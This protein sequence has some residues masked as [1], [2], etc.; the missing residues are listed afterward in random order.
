MA[1]ATLRAL[2]AGAAVLAVAVAAGC[3]GSSAPGTTESTGTD[4]TE[5]TAAIEAKVTAFVVG[6]LVCVS[7][8]E[9]GDL[10]VTWT[11]QEATAVRLE[12]DGADADDAGPSGSSVLSMPCDG[13]LHKVSVTALN[14]SG[15]GQTRS[16][17][18]S[19]S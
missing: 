9:D 4:A 6:E 7:E 17:R 13:K 2:V 8:G 3:G 12:V 16:Q 14:D 10:A 11:T 5:T 19:S 18:V 15:D 1:D